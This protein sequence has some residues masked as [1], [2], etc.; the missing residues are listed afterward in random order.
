[1]GRPLVLED[2]IFPPVSGAR[3]RAIHS[4]RPR[5]PGRSR[6]A[7]A[8]RREEELLPPGRHRPAPAPC[9]TPGQRPHELP[10]LPDPPRR[11]LARPQTP[12]LT[13]PSLTCT[14]P[15][16]TCTYLSL[17]EPHPHSP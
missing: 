7:P 9:A 4:L 10:R 16:L 14:Y 1:M 3:V 8:H 13:H 15:S 2:L 17:P 5:V 6:K 12:Y 11:C